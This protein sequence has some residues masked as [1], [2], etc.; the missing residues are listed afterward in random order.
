[1]RALKDKDIKS[2]TELISAGQCS[3]GSL[4]SRY[5]L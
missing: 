4:P 1:M 5:K 2:A 3:A